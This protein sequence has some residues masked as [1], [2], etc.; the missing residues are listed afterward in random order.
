MA[1]RSIEKQ[2]RGC[3]CNTRPFSMKR[4][5]W[6]GHMKSEGSYY[7]PYRTWLR[8]KAQ[9]VNILPNARRRYANLQVFW[10]RILKSRD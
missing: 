5:T 7:G 2:N 10:L 4:M 8:K 9:Q 1:Y 3:M 6:N